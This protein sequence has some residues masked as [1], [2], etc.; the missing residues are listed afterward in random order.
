MAAPAPDVPA[1]F[2]WWPTA[3]RAS[4]RSW[5]LNSPAGKFPVILRATPL[6]PLT[7]P[8]V[9]PP[10]KKKRYIGR[11]K[12]CQPLFCCCCCFVVF[13]PYFCDCYFAVVKTI[14]RRD[15]TRGGFTAVQEITLPIESS[16]N[17][18][19]RGGVY[20]H[21][22]RRHTRCRFLCIFNTKWSLQY[23]YIFLIVLLFIRSEVGFLVIGHRSSDFLKHLTRQ[24]VGHKV[25]FPVRSFKS[26]GATWR[27]THGFFR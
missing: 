27:K 21:L 8:P 17:W 5:P 15:K 20:L 18:R 26:K 1:A 4:R 14:V 23:T 24:A 12:G 6:P 2:P 10:N 19:R 11:L 3:S 13:A 9:Q 22:H 25:P 7:A 16:D